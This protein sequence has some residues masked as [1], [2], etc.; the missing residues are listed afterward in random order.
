MVFLRWYILIMIS[1]ILLV[2]LIGILKKKYNYGMIYA[3]IC[4]LVF[5]L[6]ILAYVIFF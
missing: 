6:P 1:V 2:K 3:L 5:Y 4:L